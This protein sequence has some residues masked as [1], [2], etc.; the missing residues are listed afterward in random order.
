MVGWQRKSLSFG[1]AKTFTL[2]IISY[3][4]TTLFKILFFHSHDTKNLH[5][6]IYF[7]NVHIHLLPIWKIN[8][9]PG[10]SSHR[11]LINYYHMVINSKSAEAC[12]HPLLKAIPYMV[13]AHFIFFPNPPLLKIFIWKYCPNEM[14][15]KHKKKLTRESYFFKTTLHAFYNRRFF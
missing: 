13:K 10:R 2:S 1:P 5:T 8:S 12:N 14:Q 11:L 6:Q 7:T 4:Q 3:S 15:D 9:I